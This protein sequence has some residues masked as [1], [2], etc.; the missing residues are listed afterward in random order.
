L[1][2]SAPEGSGAI[3]ISLVVDDLALGFE[4]LVRVREALRQYPESQGG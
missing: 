3:G 1:S 4:D 2:G